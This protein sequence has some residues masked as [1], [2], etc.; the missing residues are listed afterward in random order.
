M[1]TTPRSN[2]YFKLTT[3]D[4]GNIIDLGPAGTT[5][6]VSTMPIQ[7]KASVDFAG[8][9]GVVGRAV[10]P[11]AA[12]HAAPFES[13]PYKRV[14]VG[15]IA[16]DYAIV[17]DPI[18]ASGKIDVPANGMCI[19]LVVAISAGSCEVFPWDLQG[20]SAV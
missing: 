8:T 2:R 20:N 19:G 13:I 17:S 4:N 15:G 7:F 12:E 1:A 10:G 18:T 9:L 16:S 5:S 11:A 3:D 6:M 14:N